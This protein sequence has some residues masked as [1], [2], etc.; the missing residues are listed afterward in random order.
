VEKQ[1]QE[2]D[3]KGRFSLVKTLTLNRKFQLVQLWGSYFI[4]LNKCLEE[5][6]KKKHLWSSKSLAHLKRKAVVYFI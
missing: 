5:R 4:L 6:R 1:I 2:Q 3:S